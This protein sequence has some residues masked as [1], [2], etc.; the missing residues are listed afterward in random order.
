MHHPSSFEFGCLER[1]TVI[2]LPTCPLTWI[3]TRSSSTRSHREIPFILH[4]LIT[5]RHVSLL[6]DFRTCISLVG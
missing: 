5:P 2:S 6:L 1:G 3:Q 4:A